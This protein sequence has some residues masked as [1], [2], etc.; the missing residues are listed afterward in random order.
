MAEPLIHV[1]ELKGIDLISVEALTGKTCRCVQFL[2]FCS[3]EYR[4][5][6]AV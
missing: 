1:N 2:R 3:E 5:H 4:I 6:C